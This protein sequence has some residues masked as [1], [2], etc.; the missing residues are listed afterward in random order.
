MAEK[1]TE[2]ATPKRRDEARKKG[3]VARSMDVNSAVV[4]L[5]A[6]GLLALL[7][8]RM[9]DQMRTIMADGLTHTAD[10]SMASKEGIGELTMWAIRSTAGALAPIALPLMLAGVIAGLVQSKPNVSM[11]A[12]KPTWSKINPVAGLKRM[13]SPAS[14]FELVKAI[15]KTTIVGLVA[16]LAVWPRIPE[17]AGLVGLP[18]AAMLSEVARL[19]FHVGI[20]VAGAL[21]VLAIADLAFQKWRHERSL[22][23]TV[24]AV[25]QEARQTDLPPEVRSQIRRRQMD[26]AR[27]RMLADVPTA[28]VVVVNPTHFAVALRYDA[29]KAAPQVVAKGA[30]LVAKAIREAAEKVG[31]PILSEPPLARALYKEVEVGHQIPE[32][33]F[34]AV[35]EVLAFVYRTAARRRRAA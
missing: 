35:A 28:D 1:G 22:R 20:R 12:L 14:A 2:K 23:M 11:Q 24:D 19:I 10:P 9:L 30:D 18:P 33:F 34:A 32:A 16:F 4:L 21:I 25:K 7:A 29:S 6:F 3:Q 17:M 27:T 8:P 13:F 31:V 26:Q 5:A 15:A